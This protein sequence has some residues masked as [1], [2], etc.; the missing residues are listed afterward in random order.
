MEEYIVRV[1]GDRTEWLNKENENHRLDGP[2]VKYSNGTKLWYQNGL[3]HRIDGPAVELIDGG[4]QWW[5]EG[6][7]YSEEEFHKKL[8][9]TIELT[10]DEISKRLGFT[11]KVVGEK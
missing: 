3:L 5:I 11:V 9:P 2:A 7:E 1:Y 4:K 6:K 10:V 8:N